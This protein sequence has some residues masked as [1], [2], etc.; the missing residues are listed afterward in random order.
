MLWFGQDL[1]S[2]LVAWLKILL[3]LAALAVLSTLF[4]VSRGVN[5]EDAIPYAKVDVA[6]L[7]REPRLTNAAF[8]GMTEDGAA[9]TLK[10][11]EARPGVSGSTG[12]GLATGLSGLLETPDGGRTEVT[13]AE[14]RLDQ[15]AR[16][17][18]LSGGVTINSSTGYSIKAAGLTMSIDHTALD[19]DGAVSVQAPMG[20]ISA[21]SLHIGQADTEAKA[22]VLVFKGRVRLIYQ[23]AQ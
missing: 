3:P 12:A 20:Q 14:A 11:A 6:D 21:D 22:Y 19:S 18:I 13:A 5:P 16:Q 8:A 23:P 2:T 1:H 15:A 9:L 7:A 10:A 17:I 4:L